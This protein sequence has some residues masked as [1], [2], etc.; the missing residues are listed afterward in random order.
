MNSTRPLSQRERE[1]P[2]D[3]VVTAKL[4]KDTHRF[5]A[6]FTSLSLRKEAVQRNYIRRDN[7]LCAARKR[8]GELNAANGPLRLEQQLYVT[9]NVGAGILAN[10]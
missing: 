8:F 5:S 4:L 10:K 9:A 7:V 3:R 1:Q 6:P 2:P